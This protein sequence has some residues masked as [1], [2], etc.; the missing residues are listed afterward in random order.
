MLQ[1]DTALDSQLSSSERFAEIRTAFNNDRTQMTLMLARKLN[2]PEV[3]VIRLEG[4]LPRSLDFSCWEELT[5]RLSLSA[6]YMSLFQMVHDSEAFG[7]FGKF[8]LFTDFNAIKV[9]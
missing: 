4:D 8:I 7:Q 9:T 1:T 3:D 2:I 6:M 5:V